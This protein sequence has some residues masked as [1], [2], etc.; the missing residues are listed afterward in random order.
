[1]KTKDY[2]NNKNLEWSYVEVKGW[3]KVRNHPHH[4]PVEYV[5]VKPNKS[6]ME[7]NK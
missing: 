6:K 2:L 7:E 5:W 4:P 3:T 1:M